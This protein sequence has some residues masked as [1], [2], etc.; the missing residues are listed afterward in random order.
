V[1]R[2]PA[3]AR[4]SGSD[5]G[6]PGTWSPRE[7]GWHVSLVEPPLNGIRSVPRGEGNDLKKREIFAIIGFMTGVDPSI[8]AAS[9]LLEFRATNVRS[10][11]DPLEFS[12]HATA[13]AEDNVPREVPWREGTRHPLRVL[14]AAG[15]F[16]A[17]ASGKTN[18]LRAMDDMRRIVLTSFKNA[19]RSSRI[20]RKDEAVSR[21]YLTGRYGAI[22]IISEA[23]FA[24]LTACAATGGSEK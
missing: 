1:T 23:E 10:F 18:L 16:G 8:A 9:M 12:F 3:P 21:R 22:P 7:L 24:A 6:Q 13:M 14:P 2:C 5:V 20:P 11:R 4:L 19:S 17:N 15:I